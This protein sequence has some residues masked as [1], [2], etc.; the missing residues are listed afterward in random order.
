M[1]ITVHFTHWRKK[2]EMN[3]ICLGIK[4]LMVAKMLCQPPN[5][6][7]NILLQKNLAK[8]KPNRKFF[9]GKIEYLSNV[10]I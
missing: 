5:I 2:P 6:H 3:I 7:R 10:I 9:L 1:D 8:T 4:F